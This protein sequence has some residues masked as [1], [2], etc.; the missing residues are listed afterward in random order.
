ME[1]NSNEP[2]FS[3]P[4]LRS[5]TRAIVTGLLT[6]VFIAM[7]I[8]GLFINAESL[9]ALKDMLA[10]FLGIYGAIIGFWFGEDSA[11]KQQPDTN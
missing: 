11:T 7:L 2:R 5:L 9:N 10:I 4:H 1:K 6:L 8:I 3:I